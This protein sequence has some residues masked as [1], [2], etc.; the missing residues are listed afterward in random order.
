MK[1][2]EPFVVCSTGDLAEWLER[3]RP[4]WVARH[5]IRELV[6]RIVLELEH[7]PWGADWSGF[8]LGVEEP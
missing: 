4:H 8:L 1:R 2:D 5:G 3:S 7:P 6:R